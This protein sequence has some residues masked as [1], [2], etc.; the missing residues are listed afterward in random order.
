[1]NIHEREADAYISALTG[2]GIETLFQKLKERA[3]GNSQYSEK[4]ALVSNIR[5][6]NCLERSKDNL[7]KSL[8]SLKK[9]Y[10]GEFIASDIRNAAT[11]LGEIIGEVTSEDVLNNIFSKFCIGK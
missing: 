9:N 4:S 10:S 3:F 2:E 6:Y 1:V 5:H 11:S 8:S 7:E